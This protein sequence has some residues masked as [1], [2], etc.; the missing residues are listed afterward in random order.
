MG[1]I[2]QLQVSQGFEGELQLLNS[3]V[4]G[5]AADC[6]KKTLGEGGGCVQG[7]EAAAGADGCRQ[8]RGKVTKGVNAAL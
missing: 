1:K 6:Y 3:V 8:L 2:A 4:V 5:V 7:L